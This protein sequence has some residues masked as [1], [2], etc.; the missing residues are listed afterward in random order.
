MTMKVIFWSLEIWGCNIKSVNPDH[1]VWTPPEQ[2]V[3]SVPVVPGAG[4][5]L[6]SSP[7]AADVAPAR[8]RMLDL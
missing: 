6:S 7:G 4:W 2:Q 1:P 5:L 8:G 3:N